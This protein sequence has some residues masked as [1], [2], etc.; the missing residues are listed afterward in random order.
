VYLL[1]TSVSFVLIKEVGEK[2]VRKM[3]MKLTTGANPI[4]TQND[5][6]LKKW[7]S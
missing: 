5:D 6:K 1:T 3:L 7:F 4:K 2:S